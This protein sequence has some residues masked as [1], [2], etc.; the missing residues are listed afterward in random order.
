MKDNWKYNI[1]RSIANTTCLILMGKAFSFLNDMLCK[2]RK[3]KID[4]ILKMYQLQHSN[5]HS[6]S[7]K[8]FVSLICSGGIFPKG[9]IYY[10]VPEGIC[11]RK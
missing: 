7:F 6:F 3:S 5:Q 2:R 1:I 11:P 10:Y 8:G 9:L 4:M